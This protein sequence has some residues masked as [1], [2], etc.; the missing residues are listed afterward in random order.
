MHGGAQRACCEFC[1]ELRDDGQHPQM[2]RNGG[3]GRVITETKRFGHGD[4]EGTDET[5]CRG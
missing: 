1:D 5:S 2:P 3:V 4:A